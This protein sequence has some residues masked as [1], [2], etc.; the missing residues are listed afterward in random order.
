MRRS[1][2][3]KAA[4]LKEPVE[5]LRGTDVW[6]PPWLLK[7]AFSLISQLCSSHTWM[8][9]WRAEQTPTGPLKGWPTPSL[10]SRLCLSHKSHL[11][12]GLSLGVWAV[13]SPLYWLQRPDLRGSR[14]TQMAF[15]SQLPP[16]PPTHCGPL[17][18]KSRISKCR[19]PS[20]VSYTYGFPYSSQER[21]KYK[22][23]LFFFYQWANWYKNGLNDMPKVTPLMS[24]LT[25]IKHG[26][27]VLQSVFFTKTPD[28]WWMNSPGSRNGCTCF[29]FEDRHMDVT[30][31]Q[32]SKPV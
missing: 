16:Q 10:P 26:I 29:R 4:T 17:E 14:F 31:L 27:P 12:T 21:Y 15:A 19:A 32:F 8:G 11:P 22:M 20:S 9:F 28:A 6:F 3:H 2:S 24:S 25:G 30:A 1:H 5:D 13:A 23:L 18:G 7:A